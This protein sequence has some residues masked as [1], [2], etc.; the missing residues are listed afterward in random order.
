VKLA[1]VNDRAVLVLG[2]E[3]VDVA[4]ASGGGFGPDLMAVYDDWAAFAD[5]AATVTSGTAPLVEAQVGN[6]VPRPRQVFAIGL[7][8]RSNAWVASTSS[9]MRSTRAPGDGYA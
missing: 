5:F 9:I 4:T 3:I 1:N 6:P 2:D 7:N 8:Y